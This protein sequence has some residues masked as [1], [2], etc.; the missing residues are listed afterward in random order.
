MLMAFCV[1]IIPVTMYMDFKRYGFIYTGKGRVFTATGDEALAIIYG[2]ASAALCLWIMAGYNSLR[3]A[4]KIKRGEYS[5]QDEAPEFAICT[6]CGEP[7]HSKD[8]LV[9]HCRKCTGNVEDIEGYYDRHPEL[10]PQ[11]QTIDSK[12]HP[13]ASAPEFST[14][15][16]CGKTFYKEDCPDL[17]CMDCR[18]I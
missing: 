16:K 7:Q 17:V 14:C 1:S 15:T 12:E 3:S 10:K 2:I 11:S 4:T 8:L 13:Q 5:D 9:G 18:T 6:N